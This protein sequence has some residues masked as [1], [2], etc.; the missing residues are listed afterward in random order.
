MDEQFEKWWK[1]FY[2]DLE[3]FPDRKEVAE[4]A[5][6]ARGEADRIKEFGCFNVGDCALEYVEYCLW[7]IGA[8]CSFQETKR[9]C[10]MWR[11]I[12]G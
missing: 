9:G 7:E 6:N 11:E 3:L 5:W 2:S 8:S 4:A 1:E 12:E 10:P